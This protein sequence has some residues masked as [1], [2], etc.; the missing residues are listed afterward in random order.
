MY[1]YVHKDTTPAQTA[2]FARRAVMFKRRPV[3][4]PIPA[5]PSPHLLV[6]RSV[7]NETRPQRCLSACTHTQH[8]PLP[9]SKTRAQNITPQP[10]TSTMSFPTHSGKL[11]RHYHR[12]TPTLVQP[13]RPSRLPE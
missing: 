3:T 2:A 11:H 10:L 6:R 13:T 4:Y 7:G 8:Q 5:V 9:P 1:V 12:A